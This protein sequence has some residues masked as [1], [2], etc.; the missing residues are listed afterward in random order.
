MIKIPDLSE[1]LDLNN[2]VDMTEFSCFQDEYDS[3]SE[4]YILNLAKSINIESD[5]LS[6]YNNWLKINNKYFYFKSNNAFQELLIEKLF[7]EVKVRTVK[8]Q[9]VKFN[10]EIGIISQNYRK[11]NL[12]YYYF[13]EIITGY[14]SENNFIE[15]NN[16][17]KKAM[18]HEDYENYLNQMF[19]IIAVDILFGQYDRWEYNV[20]FA[21]SK[22]HICLA[23]MFD[24][25]CIFLEDYNDILIY[26]SCFGTLTFST[27]YEDY[28]TTNTLRKFSQMVCSLEK[29]LNFD[30][31][32]I[33]DNL[34]LEYKIKICKEIR[35]QIQ[36]YYDIHRK[37]VEKTLKFAK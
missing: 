24:N 1:M 12:L 11:P 29:A 18:K 2:I 8:H 27:D 34:E 13:S 32:K 16:S 5:L 4:K 21:K 14:S 22:E 36:N 15:I 3:S 37:M 9:I 6:T 31:S 7:E 26:G 33:F 23:P 30:L 10:D 35:T 17:I 28:F 19:K 25:G 20:F